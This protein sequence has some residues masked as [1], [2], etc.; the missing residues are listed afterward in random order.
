M[1]CCTGTLVDYYAVDYFDGTGFWAMSLDSWATYRSDQGNCAKPLGSPTS[2]LYEM[3][4]AKGWTP[5]FGA[6]TNHTN[7]A[8]NDVNHPYLF[9]EPL[10]DPLPNATAL[11]PNNQLAWYENNVWAFSSMGHYDGGKPQLPLDQQQYGRNTLAANM[12]ANLAY[13]CSMLFNVPSEQDVAI[14]DGGPTMKVNLEQATICEYP[15]NTMS[16]SLQI[17][18]ENAFGFAKFAKDQLGGLET[19][20]SVQ[21]LERASFLQSELRWYPGALTGW[22][23]LTLVSTSNVPQLFTSNFGANACCLTSPSLKCDEFDENGARISRSGVSAS[24]SGLVSVSRHESAFASFKVLTDSYGEGYC[25]VSLNQVYFDGKANVRDETS[26]FW[27]KITFSASVGPPVAFTVTFYV[28]FLN[29]EREK[30]FLPNT[31]GPGVARPEYI[32][33]IDP[34]LNK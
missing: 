25:N 32:D 27:G 28:Y 4:L 20:A 21:I 22:V 9:S 24:L 34:I 14:G 1:R 13:N 18:T 5:Y 33:E 2:L 29:M 6:W 26:Q 7:E 16:V 3:F 17:S 31:A 12:R 8:D 30:Y 10:P 23:N 11:D 19:G 15:N